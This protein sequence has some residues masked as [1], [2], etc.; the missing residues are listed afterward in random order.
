MAYLG[1]T[2]TQQAFTP[3]VDYFS[4]N[5]ST[6]AFTLSFPVASVAQVQVVIENVPQNPGDA[7]T[8]SGNVITFTSAPPSGTNNIYV[9]YT[10]PITTVITPGYGTVG[11]EQLKPGAVTAPTPTAVSDQANT[12]TGYFDLP[13]GTTAQ[14]PGSPANGMTRFNTTLGYPEWYSE[15]AGAWILF[16]DT[17]TYSI[18]YLIVA[19]GGGG[20]CQVGGGG[21][22]GGLLQ[23]AAYTVSQ[24][25]SYTLVVGAGGAGTVTTNLPGTQGVASSGFS[26]TAVG[27][28]GGGSHGNNNQASSGG[29]GGG[30][31][32]GT[33]GSV[34]GASGTSGQGYAGGNGRAGGPWSGGGGGGA[35]QAGYN[36]RRFNLDYSIFFSRRPGR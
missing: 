7:Y 17:L 10:S 28:G 1:N 35:S 27:G 6:T 34:A 24:N 19:G 32:G 36:S 30:G 8:V 5:G 4:G 11:A 31:G 33:G 2:P 20:G 12:S 23:S 14:R 18:E 22:A 3:R 26:Q 21:G 13:S 9:Y 16:S 15:A 29:S 25:T